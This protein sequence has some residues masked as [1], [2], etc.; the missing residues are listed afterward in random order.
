M[1]MH[2]GIY[3]AYEEKVEQLNSDLESK[4]KRIAELKR[5]LRIFTKPVSYYRN[6]GRTYNDK[7]LIEIAEQ[8]LTKGKR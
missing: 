2:D 6:G 1:G 7:Q 3:E 4:D 8:A 5:T